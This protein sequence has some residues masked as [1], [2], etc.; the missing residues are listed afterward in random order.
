MAQREVIV[1]SRIGL[2]S[3][4][5]ALFVK[6]VAQQAVKITIRKPEG[7]PV[8]ARSILRVLALGAKNGETVVL[9]A[10]GDGAEEALDAVAVVVAE[11]HDDP[12]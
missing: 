8:D 10:D 2:H 6:A 4:P 5:A 3:R 7:V 1:G 9:E 11:D 12:A